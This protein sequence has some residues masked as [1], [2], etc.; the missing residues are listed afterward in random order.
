M[1]KLFLTLL[2]PLSFA[3]A[4]AMMLFIYHF[5]AQ[6]GEMSSA[7]SYEVSY[8]IVEVKDQLLNTGL[9]PEQ[10][11]WQAQ[12]IH[13]YVRKA[14]HITEYLLLAIAVAFPLY[15]YGIRGICLL[16]LS[17]AIC[18]TF[19]G[20]DE[21]HQSFVESRG[22]SLKDVGIDSIGVFAGSILVQAFCWSA[23]HNPSRR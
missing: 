14:A 3:P 9:T 16:L 2:K 15:V 4:I 22:P 5:S 7:L 11:S 18:V 13:Y 21:Y 17:A 19:A 8:E 6:P 1:K 12:G 23:T 10:L 20:F